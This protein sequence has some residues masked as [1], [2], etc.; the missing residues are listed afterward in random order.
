[1]D[2]AAA[3]AAGGGGLFGGFLIPNQHQDVAIG[4]L[5]RVV[6]LPA[7]GAA[8]VVPHQFAFPRELLNAST[9]GAAT[10]AFAFAIGKHARAHQIAVGQK[11]SAARRRG[12]AFPRADDV[13]SHVNQVRFGGAEWAE[14]R[15]T[16]KGLGVIDAQPEL[17]LR[18]GL[19]VLFGRLIL[20]VF[21]DG[22][23]GRSQACSEQR[24]CESEK[25]KQPHHRRILRTG[26]IASMKMN[27]GS[28]ECHG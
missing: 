17:G 7:F 15:V 25:G 10:A 5:D 8:F 26:P 28:H 16:L 21:L 20:G 6:M 27:H 13:A 19:V 4:Q 24:Q 1:L 12:R 14:Q 11:I 18:S 2:G 3:F 23:L 22:H 9:I